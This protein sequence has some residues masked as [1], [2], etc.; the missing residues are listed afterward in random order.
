MHFYLFSMHKNDTTASGLSAVSQIFG[1]PYT[2]FI[3]LDIFLIKSIHANHTTLT[4][5]YVI[6]N[7]YK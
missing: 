4:T 1:M 6:D 7:T 2:A 3:Y 5:T